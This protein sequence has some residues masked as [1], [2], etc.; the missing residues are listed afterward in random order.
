MGLLLQAPEITKAPHVETME[1]NS[2]DHVLGRALVEAIEANGALA[3]PIEL[4]ELFLGYL[5]QAEDH[6]AGV[7]G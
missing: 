4:R 5:R 6:G 7:L 2:L 1:A 3:T